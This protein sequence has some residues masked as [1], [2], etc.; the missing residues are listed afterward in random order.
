MD[1]RM[2]ALLF[3]HGWSQAKIARRFRVDRSLVCRFLN[4]IK[5]SKQIRCEVCGKLMGKKQYMKVWI[6]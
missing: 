4:L 5:R 1:K 6:S 3:E 2:V